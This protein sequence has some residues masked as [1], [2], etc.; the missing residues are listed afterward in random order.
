V[1]APVHW[2]PPKGVL[3]RLLASTAERV[4][5]LAGQAGTLEDAA[6]S[7][8]GK[9]PFRQALQASP[10]VALIAEIK[11]RSPSLGGIA[12]SMSAADQAL[13][14]A[15]GGAAAISVLTEP[16][17]F[18][19]ALAHLRAVRDVVALPLLRKD[20]I[21]TDFQIV[22]ARA[23]GADAVLLIVAALSDADLG[24]L[25]R[26]AAALDLDV[27]VEVHDEN[28]LG[29]AVAAGAAIIGVNSRNLRTLAVS[30]DTLDRLAPLIPAQTIAVAESGLRT[31]ADLAKRR[32]AGYRAFLVG[33]RLVTERDP[34]AALA[35]LLGRAGVEA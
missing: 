4:R 13:S 18:D 5:S 33:E 19:G 11:R 15:R 25:L 34:G 16:T 29:R 23:Y 35:Q 3:G 27:L 7:A 22:E 20:F 17:F 9:A 8:P 30:P 1:Q 24:M 6:A 32:A 31:T 21:V 12:P 26:A 2:S 28:E 14:Y 10:G